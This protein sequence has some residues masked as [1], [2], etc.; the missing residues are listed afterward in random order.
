L[1]IKS[2][3]RIKIKKSEKIVQKYEM[4][5]KRNAPLRQSVKKMDL[6]KPAVG[7]KSPTDYTPGK[8]GWRRPETF[9]PI[10]CYIF[11]HPAGVICAPGIV[12]P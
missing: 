6:P 7:P 9:S 4:R 2:K 11:H 1:K 12:M 3:I 8:S 5:P 10:G